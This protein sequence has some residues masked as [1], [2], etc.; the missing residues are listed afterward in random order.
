M[1]EFIV[2]G[3]ASG[4]SPVT[5]FTTDS[6]IAVPAANNINIIGG[7][8]ITTSGAGSTITITVVHSAFQWNTV[9]SA[10]NPNQIVV[11]NGYKTNDNATRVNL[12]L[13]ATAT[14]GDTFQVMG[15]GTAGWSISQ[16]A[17]Q[18]IYLGILTTTT[19]VL[20]GLS[21]TQTH[22]SIELT[23]IVAG[24]STEWQVTSVVGN[25]TVV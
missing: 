20:G 8:G 17:N 6:G 11:E 10:T 23:C 13:P 3:P 2:F 4:G 16:N 9:T 18:K 5:Q 25:I 19:G 12:L 1:S 15:Y 7:T 22:D 21:S 24:A 14:L